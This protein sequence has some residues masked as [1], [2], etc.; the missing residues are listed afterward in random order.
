M[1]KKQKPAM[2]CREDEPGACLRNERH[3]GEG[4]LEM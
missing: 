2:P 1:E 3:G 4:V